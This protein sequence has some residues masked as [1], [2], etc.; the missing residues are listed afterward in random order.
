MEISNFAPVLIPTLNRHI[1]F[2]RC[3][4][5]LAKCT[6]A[7]KTDLYIAFDYPLKDEHWEGYNIIK[8]FLNQISGFKSVTIIERGRN[9]GAI[10]NLFN[11]IDQIFE[12]YDRVILSEDDNEFSIDFLNFINL[13]LE[14]YNN[15][16][17]V[18]SISG[19][20][21]PIKFP[22]SYKSNVYVWSGF[23][24]WGVGI[25]KDKWKKVKWDL[26]SLKKFLDCKSNIKSL[27]KIAENYVPALRKIIQTGF[28]TGDTY[29]CYHQFINEMYSIFPICTRVRNTGNDGS[30]INCVELKNDIYSNQ[31]LYNSLEKYSLNKEIGPEKRI[32][33]ILRNHFKVGLK[34]RIKKYV[35]NAF[36]KLNLYKFLMKSN[37]FN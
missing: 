10:D 9:Y 35:K 28:I 3:I 25:W 17:D 2:K 31:V 36:L 26:Y 32:Y 18:F 7:K 37:Y 20:N 27:D 14:V 16:A 24:A 19:Y 33:S 21:Y 34:K 13:G 12:D 15:R 23:S 1:H 8:Q 30:G 11:A 4:E 22:K 5:S 6:H 29:I